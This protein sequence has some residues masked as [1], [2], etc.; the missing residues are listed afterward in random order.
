[1]KRGFTLIEVMVYLALFGIIMSGIVEASSLLFLS[2]DRSQ[3]KAML[4]EEAQFFVQKSISTLNNAKAIS[5]PAAGRSA[6]ALVFLRYDG[7][8]NTLST[9]TTNYYVGTTRLNNTNTS[10]DKVSFTHLYDASLGIDGVTM[11]FYLSAR[12]P[13]GIVITKIATSTYYL[14]K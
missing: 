5:A 12:T 10:V 9:S 1:M 2:H 4:E 8:G 13:G 11:A 6:T 14:R 7:T 3:T